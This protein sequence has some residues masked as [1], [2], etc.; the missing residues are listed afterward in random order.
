MTRPHDLTSSHRLGRTIGLGLF[1]ASLAAF[2]AFAQNSATGGTGGSAA[3][4]GTSATTLGTG[5]TS[6]A[7]DGSSGSS[8]ATGGAAAGGSK[9]MSKSKS[10]ETGSGDLKGQSKAMSHD[11]GTFSKSKTKTTVGEDGVE[12]QHPHD[13]ARAGQQ[14]REVDQRG[15]FEALNGR[16]PKRQRQRR[17]TDRAGSP[18]RAPCASLLAAARFDVPRSRRDCSNK[19]ISLQKFAAPGGLRT[20]V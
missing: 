11:G 2:P 8:L 10:H 19:L 3:A 13:V 16:R 1:A 5:G 7:P 6:T 4:G 14:A 12:F 9:N 17:L 20:S 18:A 15:R